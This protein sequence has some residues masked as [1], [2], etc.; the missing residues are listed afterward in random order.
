M[1]A[2]NGKKTYLAALLL[3]AY[4]LVTGDTANLLG[5]VN[6]LIGPLLMIGMRW[7]T[8]KTTEKQ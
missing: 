3:G 1:N 5:T 6:Q 8:S 4:Y 7:V 2:L